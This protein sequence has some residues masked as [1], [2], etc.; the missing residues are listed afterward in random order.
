MKCLCIF[1]S[2]GTIDYQSRTHEIDFVLEPYYGSTNLN[3]TDAQKTLSLTYKKT[4]LNFERQNKKTS[5]LTP[6]AVRKK[7]LG[8][9]LLPIFDPEMPIAST[10]LPHLSI[11][12]EGI[13]D[14]R[15]G[16][17]V[18]VLW[19]INPCLPLYSRYWISDEYGPYIYR[20]TS[21]GHLIQT[22][23]P[24]NALLP[25][26]ASGA[27]L[28]T[29]ETLPKTGRNGNQGIFTDHIVL[30]ILTYTACRF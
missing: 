24:P 8:F 14:N 2:N 27:L 22:I 30:F 18:Y 12:A 25:R 21:S 11:D 10:A 29:S 13:V 19:V 3:F 16:T 26:D 20:F 17:S 15:D 4:T 28:F 7:Q 9:P 23:Q 1:N 6:L 5:G